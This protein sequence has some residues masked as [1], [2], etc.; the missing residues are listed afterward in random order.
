MK[1]LRFGIS[2]CGMQELTEQNFIDMKNAGVK[3]LE[4]S[5][6]PEKY[7]MLDWDGIKEKADKYGINLWSLHLPFGPFERI[8]PADSN[9][10]V[11]ENTMKIVSFKMEGELPDLLLFENQH[12]IEQN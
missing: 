5:F 6:N 4:L 7:N 1:M 2:S 9:K 3:E 10:K 12:S 11:N 8:N